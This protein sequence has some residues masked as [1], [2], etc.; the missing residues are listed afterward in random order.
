MV[1]SCPNDH[2]DQ[3]IFREGKIPITK[4][5]VSRIPLASSSTENLRNFLAENLLKQKIM[6][7]VIFSSLFSFSEDWILRSGCKLRLNLWAEASKPWP[8]AEKPNPT[9]LLSTCVWILGSWRKSKDK[10]IIFG[11]FPNASWIMKNRREKKKEIL[12]FKYLHFFLLFV[13]FQ[14]P[15]GL[16][17]CKP[18]M[19]PNGPG[20]RG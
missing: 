3:L 11:H 9:H 12:N 14:F 1:I 19:K 2:Y 5:F 7:F 16:P 18:N 10:K 4:Q 6:L 15:T 20:D 17:L 8:L 13:Y